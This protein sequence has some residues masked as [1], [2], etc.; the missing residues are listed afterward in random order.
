M[1]NYRSDDPAIYDYVAVGVAK[2]DFHDA[3]EAP[4]AQVVDQRIEQHIAARQILVYGFTPRNKHKSEAQAD[5]K[6]KEPFTDT[7][8]PRGRRCAS[9]VSLHFED[10]L[11][12]PFRM[13]AIIRFA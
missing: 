3:R 11:Y 4:F 12:F 1:L 5:D 6:G 10:A 9:M 13:S 7:L 8:E 2:H